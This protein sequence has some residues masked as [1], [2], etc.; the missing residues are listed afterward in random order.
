M[1][2]SLSNF[3]ALAATR[4]EGLHPQ[5]R[6][7]FHRNPEKAELEVVLRAGGVVLPMP[8]SRTSG[9]SGKRGTGS[10]AD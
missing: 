5:L 7:L 8:G 6:S 2:M 4:G 10:D 1:M 9:V 3:H